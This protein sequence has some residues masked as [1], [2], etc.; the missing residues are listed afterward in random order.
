MFFI[1]KVPLT[2]STNSQIKPS[3]DEQVDIV[4]ELLMK[5]L[6]GTKDPNF[7]GICAKCGEAIIGADAGLKAIDQIFHIK[8]FNCISCS[9]Y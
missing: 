2:N 8:C 3:V 1:F 4:K 9:M 6:L 7:E 5:N